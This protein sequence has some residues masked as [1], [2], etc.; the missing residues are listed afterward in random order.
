MKPAA[1]EEVKQLNEV[2]V[3]KHTTEI[4][5][6]RGDSGAKLAEARND[7]EPQLEKM[8]KE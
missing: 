8:R 3:E 1:A 5:R 7:L 2:M 6:L 4:R